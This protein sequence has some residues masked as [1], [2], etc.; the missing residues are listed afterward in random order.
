MKASLA[1][2]L[3]ALAGCGGPR[4][5]DADTGRP[6]AGPVVRQAAAFM[7]VDAD[8]YLGW[9]GDPATAEVRLI[10]WQRAISP[11]RAVPRAPEPPPRTAGCCP[12]R[13]R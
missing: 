5:V 7:R 2:A 4:V 3:A 12:S 9:E 10:P 1:L 6:V 11:D 13:W 8:G